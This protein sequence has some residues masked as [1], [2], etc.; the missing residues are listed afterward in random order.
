ML[1]I[2]KRVCDERI[3]NEISNEW[4]VNLGIVLTIADDYKVINT[5]MKEDLKR[6]QSALE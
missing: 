1:W 6:K 4:G 5:L 2:Y 3:E